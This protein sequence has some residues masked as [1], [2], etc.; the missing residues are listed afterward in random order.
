MPNPRTSEQQGNYQ[1]AN[2]QTSV[3]VRRAD[4]PLHCPLP[5][6]ALWASHP[7]VFIPIEEAADGRMQCPYCGTQF[8]LDAAG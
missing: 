3:H 5:G 7:R 8:V 1:P 4:L 6:T 2:A